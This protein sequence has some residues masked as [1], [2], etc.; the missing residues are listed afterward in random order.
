MTAP[1]AQ[2]KDNRRKRSFPCAFFVG[3]KEVWSVKYDSCMV[4]TVIRK[5][6]EARGLTREELGE[7][8]GLSVHHVYRLESG[9]R[10]LTMG[11]LYSVME[12]LQCDANTLLSIEEH[13]EWI[14]HIKREMESIPLKQRE[15][16][17]ELILKF[18]KYAN[19]TEGLG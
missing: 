16:M 8:T 7:K 2:G 14:S 10:N 3:Q 17:Q 13:S 1:E 15:G 4:G 11:T 19:G 12:A 18:V 9:E 5:L 6:R